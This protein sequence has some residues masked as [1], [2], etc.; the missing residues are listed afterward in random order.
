[1]MKHLMLQTNYKVIVGIGT[2]V[3]VVVLLLFSR[4]NVL[5]AD[6]AGLTAMPHSVIPQAAKISKLAMQD[7]TAAV[8]FSRAAPE[9]MAMMAPQPQMNTAESMSTDTS[10][11]AGAERMVIR[12]ASLQLKVDNIEPQRARV[13]IGVYRL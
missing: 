9:S 5:F 8:G 2:T 4:N 3:F 10:H 6:N 12:T 1:M 11:D 7:G 13:C